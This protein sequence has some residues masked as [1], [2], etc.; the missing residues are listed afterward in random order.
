MALYEYA[1]FGNSGGS[2]QLLETS[3]DGEDSVLEEL[4]FLV[5]RPAGHVGTEVVWSPYWG[6]SPLGCWWVLWRGEEDRDAPRRNMVRSRAVL[7]HQDA[8]GSTHTLHDLFDYLSFDSSGFDVTLM[9]EVAYALARNRRPVVVPGISTAPL[10]LLSLW[11]HLWPGARRRLS[12]RTLFGSEGIESGHP[13]DIVVIPAELR[14][15]WRIHRI[16]EDMGGPQDS[17]GA[18]WLCGG[19]APSLERILRANWERL[20]GDLSI[21]T[22]LERIATATLSLHDGT[23]R[24][25]DAFLIARTVEALDSDLELPP[26]DL[27]LLVAHVS[28]MRGATIKDIRTASL[29]ALTIAGDA[30]SSAERATSRWIRENL[31]KEA[32]ADTM[33]VLEHQ[34][35]NLH[36]AW[37]LRAIRDGLSDS[38]ANLTSTWAAALWRWWSVN[39]DAV[40]WTQTFLR[41]D[42]ATEASLF[43]LVPSD[44][45]VEVRTRLV[46]VC[47]KRQWARLLARLVRGLEP[48]EKPVRMLREMISEPE[49]G[50]DVLLERR[51]GGEVVATAATCTWQPLVDRA[52]RLTVRDPT[53]LDDIDG[54]A[55]GAIV[56]FAAHLKA[57]GRLPPDAL[58]DVIIRRVFDGCIDGDEGCLEIVQHL[59]A[60]AGAVALAYAGLD[61]L[62]RSLGVAWR[63]PLLAATATAWLDSFLADE[64]T[65]KPGRVLEEA[66]R[67]RARAALSKGPIRRVISFFFLFSDVSES[68]MVEWLSDEG[69]RWQAGDAELLG[70][71]LVE[72][73][74]AVAT[75]SFRC[76]WKN[77]L[78]MVAWQARSLLA[79]WDR[80]SVPPPGFTDDPEVPI[81]NRSDGRESYMKILFLAA[82]PM[83][84]PKLSIDEEVRAIEEKVCSSKLRDAVQFR[85]RWATRPGDLQQALLEEDPVVVHFSGH[86]GSTVGVVLHSE[87]GTDVSLVS[88]AT[89]ARLFAVLKDNIRLVVLNTCYSEEPGESIVDEIDFVVGMADS[90]G[91]D[92][93]RVFAAALYRGLAFGKSVQTAF[94]LGLN[95]L[96]LMGLK[97]DE[98]VPVLLIREGV[99]ASAV[100]LL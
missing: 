60:H 98:D 76:S 87:A 45:N 100:T 83:T 30:V 58:G 97:D 49:R 80:P 32:D 13:P 64:Q 57:G 15:R 59:G 75:R 88:S 41:A 84:S 36:V 95:E 10:L 20:P 19:T 62:W 54:D 79:Y 24:L 21:L 53:L 81:H 1:I 2:H 25:A 17:I 34:A 6:C 65:T 92:G 27:A 93:A 35:G 68:E 26:E 89:L 72:R 5:D 23:G 63:E 47:A 42:S 11:P 73:R 39:P 96:Q 40:D 28:E 9:G 86:G 85:S 8:V 4:R 70:D 71:L 94:D 67:S 61:E 82:N 33:W 91:D 29:V 52:G 51:A 12:L 14:P 90:I 99:D 44:V 78:K 48:L 31:P 66:V 46:A 55:P 43:A 77:E 56:L 38:L 3:L 7:V 50:L 69:F 74:W 16:V 22:R 18:S 37:W